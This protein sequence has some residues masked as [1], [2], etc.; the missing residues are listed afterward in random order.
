MCS[1]CCVRVRD[2][3]SARLQSVAQRRRHWSLPYS[4]VPRLC[5]G[6]HLKALLVTRWSLGGRGE[7]AVKVW[8]GSR[9]SLR[10][11]VPRLSLGTRSAYLRGRGD[12]LRCLDVQRLLRAR[13]G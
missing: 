2:E 9:R 1:G 11:Q 4:L 10:A 6:T 13:I 5:L 7:S 12:R 3:R 8:K